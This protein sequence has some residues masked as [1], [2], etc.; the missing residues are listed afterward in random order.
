MPERIVVGVPTRIDLEEAVAELGDDRVSF[1]AD[2]S[3]SRGQLRLLEDLRESGSPVYLELDDQGRVTRMLLPL[4]VTVDRVVPLG[5]DVVQVELSPSHARHFLPGADEPRWAGLRRTLESAARERTPVLVTEDEDHRIVDVRPVGPDV[6]IPPMLPPRAR[7]QPWWR[8]FFDRPLFLL[9]ESLDWLLWWLFPISSAKARLVFDALS[10]LTCHPVNVPPPCIPFLYPDDGCWGRAHE[11]CR[12][13]RGMS[14]RSRKWWIEGWLTVHTANNPSCEV[15][16]G[17]HV[18]P[19]VRVRSWL[20]LSRTRVIDPALFDGPVS[21]ATWQ[22]AQNDANSHLTDSSARIFYLWGAVTDAD[23]SQTEGV[24]ATY[25][26]HLRNR[27]LS[28]GA[29]PYAHCS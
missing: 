8:R 17:W 12:L 9:S 26:S 13:M 3:R 22:G 1:D 4:V 19:K 6:R 20:F 10:T 21:T 18:A 24:L 7:L 27:S 29:P 15:H 23:N 2:D 28:V 5:P 11:M 25:R 14:V 16:W